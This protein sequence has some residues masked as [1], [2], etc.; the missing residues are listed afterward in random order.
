MIERLI[1]AGSGGQGVM[2]LGKI[3]AYA[4]MKQGLNVT[5]LPSYGAEVRGGTAHCI[6]IIS[7]S[8]IGSPYAA[9]ADTMIIMNEPSLQK[10]KSR[11]KNNGLL[12]VNS[13]LVGS[14]IPGNACVVSQPFTDIA[15]KMGNVRIA[16]MVA[17][18]CYLAQR[19]ILN[20]ESIL[21]TI[22][23]IAPA[24]KKNLV[25][26]NKDALNMGIKLWNKQSG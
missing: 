22:E 19:K 16:N 4:A 9:K 3:V 20:S 26:I 7:D 2:L 24:D 5:W 8:R 17:L 25:Q 6:V 12:I 18:G 23:E 21:K 1:I 11:I 14:G 15:I 10:F 13:S